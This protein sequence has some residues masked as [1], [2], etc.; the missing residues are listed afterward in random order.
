MSLPDEFPA[1]LRAIVEAELL[2]G[3]EIVEVGHT[4]PAPPAGAYVKLARV[5][6]THPH[7][8]HGGVLYYLRNT[9]SYSGEFHDARRFYFVLEPPLPPP[10]PP[11]MDAI[12]AAVNYSPPVDREGVVI[13]SR[14]DASMNI[15]Y[16]KWREGIGYDLQAIADASPRERE[17]IEQKLLRNGIRGWRDVEA[18]AAIGSP[19]AHAAL[20]LA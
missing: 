9:S 17:H 8:S 7:L 15:D 5:V 11:D 6:T 4:H 3:N 19:A 16:E 18:L 20:K 1:D 14:F 13:E 2:A 10:T 12:R